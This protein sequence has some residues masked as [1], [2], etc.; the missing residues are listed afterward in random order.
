M[1]LAVKPSTHGNTPSLQ[2]ITCTTNKKFREDAFNQFYQEWRRDQSNTMITDTH[3]LL[4]FYTTL[5]LPD[6]LHLPS[7]L[8][9]PNTRDA[10]TFARLR[11][12]RA[13]L[14]QSLYARNRSDTDECP[15]CRNTSE[16]IEHV[17][18]RYGRARYDCKFA[19]SY[20]SPLTLTLPLVLGSHPTLT[21]KTSE[22]TKTILNILSIFINNIRNK[23]IHLLHIKLA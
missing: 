15:T 14:N 17:L 10:T 11:L 8:S 6:P 18:M 23:L 12:N 7:Y 13:R 2:A 4:P 20:H 21:S 3:S 16:S 5:S 19:L 1:Q 9:H 22:K